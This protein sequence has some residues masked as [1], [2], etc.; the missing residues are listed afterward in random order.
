MR[1]AQGW[2]ACKFPEGVA[3]PKATPS[4]VPPPP[5]PPPKSTPAPEAGGSQPATVCAFS[6]GDGTGGS[7]EELG[8]KPAT[9]QECAA[10][11][12]Q[13]KPSANGVTYQPQGKRCFA[14][15]GMTGGAGGGRGG[16]G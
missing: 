4:P 6:D 7:E 13:G 8:Q 1:P 16:G 3:P 12:K 5:P 11:V 15:T 9:E 2:R 10:A 14:E